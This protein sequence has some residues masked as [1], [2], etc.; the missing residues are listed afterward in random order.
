MW[1]HLTLTN[2]IYSIFYV[3]LDNFLFIKFLNF[4]DSS[5]S[6]I[7]I[8]IA[9]KY[10]WKAE[11]NNNKNWKNNNTKKSILLGE[12]EYQQGMM[13]VPGVSPYPLLTIIFFYVYVYVRVQQ[14]Q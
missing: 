7:N 8:Y 2:Y 12:K 6:Y 1:E 13:Q 3:S 5:L 14:T 4:V 11:V 10:F 9:E